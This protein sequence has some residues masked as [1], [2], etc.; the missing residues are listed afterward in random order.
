MDINFLSFHEEASVSKE[1]TFGPR[2]GVAEEYRMIS[3]S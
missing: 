1:L 3:K 2:L